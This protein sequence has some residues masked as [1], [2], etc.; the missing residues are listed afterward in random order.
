MKETKLPK[1][2]NRIKD[3][4]NDGPP[5]NFS[6]GDLK[7]RIPILPPNKEDDIEYA[8]R[9]GVPPY[10]WTPPE[11]PSE[12]KSRQVQRLKLF[13]RDGKTKAIKRSA[14]Q[15]GETFDGLNIDGVKSF[16]GPAA[17]FHHS[18][19]PP[20][21]DDSKMLNSAVAVLKKAFKGAAGIPKGG[22]EDKKG[23][24]L[25]PFSTGSEEIKKLRKVF[26]A[27]QRKKTTMLALKRTETAAPSFEEAKTFLRLE[28][29]FDLIVKKIYELC[30]AIN[31]GILGT[32]DYKEA[33]KNY[34]TFLQNLNNP[35]PK[36]KIA[37]DPDEALGY[38]RDLR[39]VLV[40]PVIAP[41]Q[42][43]KWPLI[44][45]VTVVGE[46]VGGSHLSSNGVALP[47][48]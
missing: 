10:N 23:Q 20:H 47:D 22:Q 46:W 44:T 33:R 27:N 3:I 37:L 2:R 36:G 32:G 18:D 8:I 28:L 9:E 5:S 1:K 15:F 40:D 24:A 38:G 25:E 7:G 6:A 17:N 14:K 21:S 35:N 43:G 30:N 31:A 42:G 26:L 19:P 39:W 48:R 34:I 12:L 13:L 29:G 16:A 4:N 45:A 11:H 41:V